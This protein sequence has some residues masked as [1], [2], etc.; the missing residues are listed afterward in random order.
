V[1]PPFLSELE[2]KHC[3][4]LS[5]GQWRMMDTIVASIPQFK[6]A[7]EAAYTVAGVFEQIGIGS[8]YHLS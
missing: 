8:A 1:V 7:L 5:F 4:V 6:K 3:C 2:R